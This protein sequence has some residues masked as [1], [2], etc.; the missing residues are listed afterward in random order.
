MEPE[1][2]E[3]HNCEVEADRKSEMTHDSMVTVRLS[4]PQL[5]VDTKSAEVVPEEAGGDEL[6]AEA[7]ELEEIDESLTITTQERSGNEPESAISRDAESRRGSD[8]SEG[9]DEVNWEELEKTEEQE[10]RDQGSDDV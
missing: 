4:E 8:S 9:A 6:S 1:H 7:A 2:N 5:T 3:E 10:P